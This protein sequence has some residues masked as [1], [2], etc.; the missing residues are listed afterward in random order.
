MLTVVIPSVLILSFAIMQSV[1]RLSVVKKLS[2][3]K[4]SAVY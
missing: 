2:I 3:V 1:N 4:Q